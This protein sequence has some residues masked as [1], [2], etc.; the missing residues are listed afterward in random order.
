MMTIFLIAKA[1]FKLSQKKNSKKKWEPAQTILLQISEQCMSDE[2][3]KIKASREIEGFLSYGNRIFDNILANTFY[4]I[5]NDFIS[6]NSEQLDIDVC[7]LIFEKLLSLDKEE[8]LK[9]SEKEAAK[10]IILADKIP[11]LKKNEK[12]LSLFVA[13]LKHL[14]KEK[15]I[16]RIHEK[17][18]LSFNTKLL[19]SI[20]S[21]I[22]HFYS[23][24]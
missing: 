3:V 22:N 19:A 16:Y 12:F 18:E 5:V 2:D 9:I 14:L 24:D 23:S 6:E 4:G 10:L 1:Y 20:F 21:F 11:K 15:S 13:L 8:T 17:E 7:L